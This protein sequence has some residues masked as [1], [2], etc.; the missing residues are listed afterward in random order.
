MLKNGQHEEDTKPW[1]PQVEDINTD[2]SSIYLTS[3]QLIPISGSSLNY[4]S[5]FAPTN[6]FK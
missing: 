4:E 1:I 2:A 6:F 5:Y 3:T